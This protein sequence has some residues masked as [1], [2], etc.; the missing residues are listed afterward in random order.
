MK[1]EP[2]YF[3]NLGYVQSKV[4]SATLEELKQEAKFILENSNQ[5]KKYNIAFNVIALPKGSMDYPGNDGD[6]ADAS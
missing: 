2:V 1:I 5:F 6:A 4:S 3:N